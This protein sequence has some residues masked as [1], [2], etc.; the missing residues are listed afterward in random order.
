MKWFRVTATEAFDKGFYCHCYRIMDGHL[1]CLLHVLRTWL[2]IVIKNKRTKPQLLGLSPEHYDHIILQ[3]KIPYKGK[4]EASKQ[5]QAGSFLPTAAMRNIITLPQLQAMRYSNNW[6]GKMCPLVP[7]CLECYGASR[8]LIGC[9][10][11]S[12]GGHSCLTL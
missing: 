4:T 12:T 10:A 7:K 8:Q 2:I 6:Q 9:E 5:N 3:L 1:S 11:H